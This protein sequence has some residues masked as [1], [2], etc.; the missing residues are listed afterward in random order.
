MTSSRSLEWVY[1][2]WR[3]VSANGRGFH[4]TGY[5]AA[6]STLDMMRDAQSDD[7]TRMAVA[8]LQ[9]ILYEDPPAAFLVRL[10]GARAVDDSFVVPVEEPG[11]GHPR[12]P[13]A[14]EAPRP[15]PGASRTMTRITSR[16]VLLIATRR[17]RTS[18][19]VRARL[20]RLPAQRNPGL[21]PRTATARSPSRWPS[22]SASI[23]T[24][25]FAC[26]ESVGTE[27]VDTDLKPWQQNRILRNHVL[28]FPEFREITLFDAGGRHCGD[29]PSRHRRT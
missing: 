4:R 29:Q 1:W 8:D 9:R 19:A 26:C 21:R 15:R 22:E 2:F 24:T 11:T 27:L 20:G 23:S 18:D 5:T 12:Q 16:F 10:E 25:T 13:A 6:D 14:V 17:R 7:E 28:D 3:S